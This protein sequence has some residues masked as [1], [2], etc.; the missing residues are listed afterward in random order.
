MEIV[1]E[2]LAALNAALAFLDEWDLDAVGGDLGGLRVTSAESLSSGSQPVAITGGGDR[3]TTIPAKTMATSEVA[4]G[5]A[6]HA[7]VKN[8]L[9]VPTSSS[10]MAT[11]QQRSGE[12][13]G[14][15]RGSD[16]CPVEVDTAPRHKKRRDGDNAPEDPRALALQSVNL[17]VKR[18]RQKE[19]LLELRQKVQQLESRLEL[20]KT[21]SAP[22]EAVALATSG[23]LQL[24][25]PVIKHRS[26]LGVVWERL[27]ARQLKERERAE[28]ENQRLKEM[29]DEHVK[30]ARSLDRI[31]RKRATA[32]VD[33]EE[34]DVMLLRGVCE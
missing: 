8:E 4:T 19:E 7:S 20:M 25:K 13:G 10:S 11:K 29:L 22:I 15:A 12:W 27:A 34:A 2:D 33:G 9:L 30:L 1:G 26:P 3:L 21:A 31:L 18:R 6:E 14:D 16:V 23:D 32:Q 24:P 28:E 5:G 17:R